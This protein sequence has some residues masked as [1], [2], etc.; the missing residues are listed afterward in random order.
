M[1]LEVLTAAVNKEI[2]AVKAALGR[3]VLYGGFSDD[4]RLRIPACGAASSVLSHLLERNHG[5]KTQRQLAV[6]G[7][8]CVFGDEPIRHVLLHEPNTGTV[9]DPTY[10]QFLN[11]V[12]VTPYIAREYPQLATL[13]PEAEVAVVPS[14]DEASFGQRYAQHALASRARVM[15]ELYGLGVHFME[16]DGK[17]LHASDDEITASYARVWMPERYRVHHQTDDE[18]CQVAWMV[19]A[20]ETAAV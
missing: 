20:A 10:S 5:I 17:L 8:L 19:S 7:E 18:T 6:L 12:G 15:S 11:Q 14:G 2:P 1:N 16:P 9:I 13:F 3:H 4:M